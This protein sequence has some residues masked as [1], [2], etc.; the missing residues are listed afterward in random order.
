MF[1]YER[2]S[3]FCQ[4]TEAIMAYEDV[5]NARQQFPEDKNIIRAYNERRATVEFWTRQLLDDGYHKTDM[6][7]K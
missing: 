6:S 5:K 3:V 4:L 7:S 2:A 1:T